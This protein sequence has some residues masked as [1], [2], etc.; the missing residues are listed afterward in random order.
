MTEVI[1]EV[2]GVLFVCP[3]FPSFSFFLFL[4]HFL[5]FL[6]FFL[7]PFPY[8]VSGFFFPQSATNPLISSFF[9]SYIIHPFFFLVSPSSPPFLPL[10]SCHP[11]HLLSFPCSRVTLFTSFSS[12]FLFFFSLSFFPKHLF[13]NRKHLWAKPGR[14]KKRVCQCQPELH[15]PRA[16]RSREEPGDIQSSRADGHLSRASGR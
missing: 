11:L 9:L 15:H 12:P 10:F 2:I 5:F 7:P 4:F 6:L 13:C 3:L 16:F 1:V 14:D 8:F